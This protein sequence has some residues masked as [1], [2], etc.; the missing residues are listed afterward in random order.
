MTGNTK[1]AT[2]EALTAEVRA[3][4]V[5][6]RQ[7][8]LSVY[9]Q[10]DTVRV[11]R[12]E[13]FGRVRDDRDKS[14]DHGDIQLVGRDR[15]DGAL[16]R[17]CVRVPGW[18]SYEDAPAA[19]NHWVWHRR[20]YEVHKGWRPVSGDWVPAAR[21]DSHTLWWQFRCGSN[22][23]YHPP[24]CGGKD[25][26]DLSMLEAEWQ[27]DAQI[28]LQDLAAQQSDYDEMAALPLIVLAGLK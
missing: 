2:V 1:T 18:H 17:A 16:I 3:L 14:L 25:K 10:L 9:R 13:P 15:E 5:G 6:S 7:I 21:H 23:D 20:R 24:G 22:W 11:D 12:I 27:P 28:E 19:F 26:C 8:T 4:M